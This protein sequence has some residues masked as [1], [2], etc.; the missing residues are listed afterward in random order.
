LEY[1][2]AVFRMGSQHYEKADKKVIKEY[3]RKIKAA[4][5]PH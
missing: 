4:K 1:E 2:D 3:E 5:V